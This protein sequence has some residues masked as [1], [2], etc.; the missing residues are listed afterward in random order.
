[1]KRYFKRMCSKE[2]RPKRKPL[3]K[4]LWSVLGAFISIYILSKFSQYFSPQDG[5]FLLGS[6]GA[7]AV[8]V[9]GAPEVAFSQPRN[10]L[11]G[12]IFS[13]FVSVFLVKF[14]GDTLEFEILCALSVSLSVLIMH[15]TLTMHPPGGATALIYVIGSEEIRSLGWLYPIVPIAVAALI[16]LLVA[17]II[18]NLSSNTKRHYPLY[19]Y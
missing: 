17:L 14:F 2:S 19:W 8:L 18:N 12:H 6:F 10:L 13:A 16:M 15:F 4:I 1:M 5:F 3:S 7:S 11:G 9:Y